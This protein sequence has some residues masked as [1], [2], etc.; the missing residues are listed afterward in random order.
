MLS[1]N[2]IQVR[3]ATLD[4]IPLIVDYWIK[5]SDQH[6]VNMGVDL[7]KMPNKD[8]LTEALTSAVSTKKSYALI[9]EFQNEAIGHTNANNIIVGDS[10]FMHIHLWNNHKRQKGLGTEFIKK[11]LPLYFHNLQ[12]KTLY[13]EPYAFNDAPNKT[14]KRIGFK[15]E[16]THTTIPGSINF[17]QEVN[18]WKIT[19]EML[20]NI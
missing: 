4:D 9:W 7:K 13:C 2:E 8:D 1:T 18:R 5:S 17:E 6:L 19:K 20:K 10:A 16:K 15:F 3:E 12:L 11:S 14:L